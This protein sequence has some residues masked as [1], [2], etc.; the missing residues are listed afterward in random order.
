MLCRFEC[1]LRL[2]KCACYCALAF[3]E[4]K[5]SR[6]FRL[7]LHEVTLVVITVFEQPL[8]FHENPFL[9]ISNKLQPT[10][11]LPIK[12]IYYCSGLTNL[13]WR[14]VR[15]QQMTTK[16][17]W[18]TTRIFPVQNHVILYY[19]GLPPHKHEPVLSS[20]GL[21]ATH[22]SNWTFSNYC[23][24]N[25]S[26]NLFTYL[27]NGVLEEICADT[28]LFILRPLPFKDVAIWVCILSFSTPQVLVP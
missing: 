27:T 13:F 10:V 16:G 8:T 3:E 19:K 2:L 6:P 24:Q 21:T 28:M 7:A 20:Q 4:E 12:K 23:T 25:V 22:S 11:N 9:P 26:V 14:N 1:P 17:R 15:L 5:L 18:A